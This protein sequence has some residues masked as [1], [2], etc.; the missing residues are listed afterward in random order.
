[1][2][3]TL[4]YCDICGDQVTTASELFLIEIIAQEDFH[5]RN[6]FE[7][8]PSCALKVGLAEEKEQSTTKEKVKFRISRVNSEML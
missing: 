2:R 7:L 1:M 4:L 6:N 3:K 8:C 5:T